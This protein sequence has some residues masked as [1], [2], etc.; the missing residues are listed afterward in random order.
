MMLRHYDIALLP[1]AHFKIWGEAVAKIETKNR[2]PALEHRGGFR[3]SSCRC[4]DITAL[5]VAPHAGALVPATRSPLSRA[6]LS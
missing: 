3:P 4:H 5:Q 6:G 1:A 2:M